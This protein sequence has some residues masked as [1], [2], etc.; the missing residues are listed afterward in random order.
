MKKVF[1]LAVSLLIIVSFISCTSE[2]DKLVGIWTMSKILS[3]ETYEQGEKAAGEFKQADSLLQRAFKG[4]ILELRK[5]KTATLSNQNQNTLQ[6]TWKMDDASGKILELYKP[7]A[8]PGGKPEISFWPAVK[9][10]ESLFY[11]KGID[12]EITAQMIFAENN[13]VCIAYLSKS[14]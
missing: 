11:M 13:T 12:T 14:K 4:A 3:K 9:G 7:G 1:F 5:D 8:K 10:A 2:R 6:Y